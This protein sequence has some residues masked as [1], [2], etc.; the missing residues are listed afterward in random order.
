MSKIMFAALMLA[1]SYVSVQAHAQQVAWVC[2]YKPSAATMQQDP[3]LPLP[4]NQIV[5]I[6]VGRKRVVSE[7]SM[8]CAS[9]LFPAVEYSN[10]RAV[11][12]GIELGAN[13]GL[14]PS[15]LE[16]SIIVD[17][18]LAAQPHGMFA[19]HSLAV[20]GNGNVLIARIGAGGGL[21]LS[22]QTFAGSAQINA[23][24]TQPISVGGD[25][26]F[27]ATLKLYNLNAIAKR[28]A[29]RAKY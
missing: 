19:K 24:M 25:V 29:L 12:E 15:L 22:P 8:T 14:R 2:T 17:G 16:N 18:G 23:T 3:A 5:Q 4:L 26:L 1:L 11:L 28:A 21:D 20:T 10:V 7:G 27:S 13:V 9:P 6:N